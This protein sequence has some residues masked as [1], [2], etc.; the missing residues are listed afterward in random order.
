VAAESSET[1]SPDAIDDGPQL[2]Q[3]IQFEPSSL[4][5]AK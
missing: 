5:E 3:E 4:T 1:R 2:I